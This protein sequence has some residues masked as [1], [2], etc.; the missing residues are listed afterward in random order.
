MSQEDKKN[1][2]QIF[3][4]K[5]ETS[6]V[7]RLA[8]FP[9]PPWRDF[10]QEKNN[11]GATYQPNDEQIRLVNAALY[12]RRP[13][14]ITGNP[15]V[16]K[17]SLA[18]AVA[19]ALDLGT[20]FRWSITTR[21]TLTEGLYRY[22]AIGRMQEAQ[23]NPDTAKTIKKYLTLGPLV[24]ALAQTSNNRPRVLLIDEI[25]KSDIDLP[26]DLLNIFEEGEFDIPEL[27][28][29]TDPDTHNIKLFQSEESAVIHKGKLR[30]KQF[31]F[32]IMT[33]NGERDFPAPFLRRCLR[34]EINPPTADELRD[35]VQAHLSEHFKDKPD[36]QGE[37]NDL[38]KTFIARR[39]KRDLLANDQLLNAV[40]LIV[41]S[42]AINKDE[43]I[44]ALL[45]SLGH[46][47]A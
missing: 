33:S 18:Y 15:G 7:S 44:D 5:K 1:D 9:P 10:E 16:G 46:A 29:I 45:R 40:Y 35:I 31:P 24:S 12:L 19:E 32:V 41:H 38:V 22:D 14:L 39:D 28:R 11:R 34:L 47:D 25:D 26:N 17:S 30:C 42:E 37:M 6:D 27:A 23:L 2:W 8:N 43:L 20:V 13:L 3:T 21:S 4:G 36:W